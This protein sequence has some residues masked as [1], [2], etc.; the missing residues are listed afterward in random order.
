MERCFKG[1]GDFTWEILNGF[2]YLTV[3]E[4]WKTAKGPAEPRQ[5]LKMLSQFYSIEEGKL[6][7]KLKVFHSS[8]SNSSPVSVSLMLSV[9]IENNAYLLFPNMTELSKIYG[10]L[11]VSATTV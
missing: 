9:V 11:P 8:Y 1:R 10:T 3:P 7:T 2:H 6:Q 5:A 4:N